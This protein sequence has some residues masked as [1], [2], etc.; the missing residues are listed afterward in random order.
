MN[1]TMSVDYDVI[2]E[3]WAR[4]GLLK[5]IR[6]GNGYQWKIY[7]QHNYERPLFTGTEG[8]FFDAWAKGETKL[9][10]DL[11]QIFWILNEASVKER[12]EGEPEDSEMIEQAIRAINAGDKRAALVALNRVITKERKERE[13]EDV[14]RLE[15]ARTLLL[16]EQI[17]K[18]Q[19]FICR[20]CGDKFGSPDALQEHE[21]M[22][23]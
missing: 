19:E 15:M 3:T 20:Q 7:G 17:G 22:C 8:T 6:N 5:V 18:A 11:K 2:D 16:S 9:Y 1:V 4:E 23:L 14:Q 21:K 12:R 10:K 13:P